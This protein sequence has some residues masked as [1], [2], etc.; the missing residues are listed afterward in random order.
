MFNKKDPLIGAVQQVM[1]RNQAEREAINQVNE[2]YGITDRRAL[3]HE[4]QKEWDATLKSVLNESHD[5]MG[6]TKKKDNESKEYEHI[7]SGKTI[8]STKPPGKEWKLKEEVK[9]PKLSAAQKYHLDVDNDDDIDAKD[10]KM[11]RMGMEEATFPGAPS[12]KMP[13]SMA[14]SSKH[15]K[16]YNDHHREL[17]SLAD[18]GKINTPAGKKQ[19]SALIDKIQGIVDNHLP[20]NPVPSKKIWL[21]EQM[22]TDPF[23]EKDAGHDVV[24]PVVPKPKP[25]PQITPAD[26]K[27]L[28]DKIKSIKEED[29]IDE[30]SE[31]Q[32]RVISKVMKKWKQGK[33][34]IGKSDKTVPNTPTG[35]KQAVAI[36]LSKAGMSKKG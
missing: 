35:Q 29:Q 11:K 33:E 21:E 28:G 24:T 17:K 12:V 20:G 19:A 15:E 6:P 25:K 27:A 16:A 8:R 5:D 13:K 3:P 34:H 9:K 1:Q 2:Y 31:R 4:L 10:L 18:S 7:T 14:P 23:A 32:K 26:Q 30:A 36:A 22:M